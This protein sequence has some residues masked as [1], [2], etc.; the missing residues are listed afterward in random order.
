MFSAANGILLE[1]GRFFTV[2]LETTEP[3]HYRD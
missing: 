1:G 3:L 2:S